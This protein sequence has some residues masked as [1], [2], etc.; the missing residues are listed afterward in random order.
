MTE[1]NLCAQCVMPILHV[2]CAIIV[3]EDGTVLA[4]QRGAG[5]HLAGLWEF[6]GGKVEEGETPE[7]ALIRE[8]REELAIEVSCERAMTPVDWDYGRGPMRL[9]PYV[10]RIIEG[11]PQALE[12]AALRWCLAEDLPSL[13][14]AAA[15]V[16]V[17]REYLLEQVS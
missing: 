12:H 1:V 10:C 17:W 5:G 6:P 14:W 16:P 2:V 8:L 15:D 11:E 9:L 7:D 3:R 13:D 4:C